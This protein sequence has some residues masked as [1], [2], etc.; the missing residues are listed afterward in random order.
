MTDD[1]TVSHTDEDFD[2]ATYRG[3][4]TD[5]LGQEPFTLKNNKLL[6]NQNRTFAD[7]V[8]NHHAT[9]MKGTGEELKGNT[10]VKRGAKSR[11]E[12]SSGNGRTDDYE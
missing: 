3:P 6:R 12:G 5:T 9:Q 8:I 2:N 7:S 10:T 4:F 11:Y 1:L